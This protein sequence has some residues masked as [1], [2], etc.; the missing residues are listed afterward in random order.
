VS[1]VNQKNLDRRKRR[2]ERRLRPRNWPD[3]P[4]PMFGGSVQYEVSDR[5]RAT[6]AGGI[7]AVHMMVRNL[8][9]DKRINEALTLLKVHLPYHESDH[10]LNIAYNVMAGGTKLEDIELLRQDESYMD[11]LGAQR[12]PDPTT[13]G[14]F[15]RRFTPSEIETYMDV[16]NGCRVPIWRQQSREFREQAT[17]DVDGS[18][19]PTTGEKKR[20]MEMS[21]KG[22]WGYHPL[23]VTLANSR[24]PLYVVNRSGNVPSHSG[25]VKW[26]DKAIDLCEP[27]FDGVFLRGDT[28]FSLTGEFDRWTDRGVTFVF[29]YDARPNVVEL[30]EGLPDGAF[31]PLERKERKVKTRDR[32]KREKVKEGIVEAR[33]F[34][35]QRLEYEEVAEVEYQPGKCRRPYRLVILRK[36]ISEREGQGFLFRFDRYF[37]YIT[38][39]RRMTVREVVGQA[40]ERCD[41]ENVIEQLKNGVNALR[42]PMYDLESNWAYMAIASLAWT[43]KAWFGMTLPKPEDGERVL[44]MEFKRF[45]N[46]LMRIP[47]QVVRG[48]RQIRVRVLAY[49]AAAR[50]LLESVGATSQ[51][52]GT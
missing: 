3:Q 47:C 1:S 32:D 7:G 40:N 10:V 6:V 26:I 9:L 4:S 44:R 5:I 8:G 20:G 17:I 2:I 12:I 38:N 35:N 22:I 16:V 52:R 43:L 50:M 14:D 36:T 51:F 42:V 48:A 13:S 30:A 23:I 31:S 33:G 39:D 41:Q 28:D 18:L 24:E 29:G 21:Y 19:T 27:E 49:T 37:F 46:Q 45:L 25:A 11:M 15:L 34:L